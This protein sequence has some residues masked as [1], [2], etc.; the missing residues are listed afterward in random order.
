LSIFFSQLHREPKKWKMLIQGEKRV[1]RRDKLQ[2]SRKKGR[3]A[4][5]ATAG[6]GGRGGKGR[7]GGGRVGGETTLMYVHR[8]IKLP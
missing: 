1:K 8:E 3:G 7:R 2:E 5:A 4:A 6:G